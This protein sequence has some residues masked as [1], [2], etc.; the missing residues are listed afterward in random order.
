MKF[1]DFISNLAQAGLQADMPG[2][3]AYDRVRFG[4]QK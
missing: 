1:F 3:R 2:I 4:S